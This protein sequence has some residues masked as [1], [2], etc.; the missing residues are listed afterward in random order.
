MVN[1]EKKISIFLFIIILSVAIFVIFNV[2]ANT[3]M[4]YNNNNSY[5]QNNNSNTVNSS[6]LEKKKQEDN[7]NK[8]NENINPTTNNNISEDNKSNDTPNDSTYNTTKPEE[9]SLSSY[10]TSIYDKDQNRVDNITLANSKL[11]GVI[12]KK[13]EEFSF[14]ST[15]GPMNEAQGFKKA[16]GFDSKG[17]KIKIS[18]GGLC[19]ISSTLYNAVLDANLEVI[20]RH[21]HSRRVYYVPKDKDATILY[22]TLDFK[23]KNN[24]DSD[25]KIEATNDS[26]NVTITLKKMK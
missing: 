6:N 1:N 10:T 2:V 15:I 8:N 11:N 14:N 7:T 20:E 17:K 9:V 25:I 16:I 26:T 12:V 3:N 22:G 5:N 18:G 21:A 13:G 19:Q 4:L 23:F 24:S